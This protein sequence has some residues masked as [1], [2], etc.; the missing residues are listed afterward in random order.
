LRDLHQA[1]RNGFSSLR[2]ELTRLR[3]ELVVVKSQ[4]ASALRRMDGVAAAAD[5]T[6]SRNG[7]V[8]ERLA[9]IE[10][11][12][13]GLGD[14]LPSARVGDGQGGGAD[15]GSAALIRDIKVRART[16]LASSVR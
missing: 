8:L 14:R 7:L 1:V 15:D 9:H 5:G 10:S 4:S 2:R 12:L 13:G 11:V 3:A 16:A 6:E